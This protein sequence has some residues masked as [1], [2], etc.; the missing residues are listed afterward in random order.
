MQDLG[1]REESRWM[2]ATWYWRIGV[3]VDA[4]TWESAVDLDRQARLAE[5]QDWTGNTY[6]VSATTRETPARAKAQR[7][8]VEEDITTVRAIE[9][10]I[11]YPAQRIRH[12]TVWISNCIA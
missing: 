8:L 10:S 4:E 3:G 5:R 11:G 2:D 7:S 12:A 6:G 9:K 1:I